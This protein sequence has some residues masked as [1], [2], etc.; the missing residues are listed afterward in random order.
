MSSALISSTM[1]SYSEKQALLR[2][3]SGSKSKLKKDLEEKDSDGEAGESAEIPYNGRV[4][5]ARKKAPLTRFMKG[6]EVN[7]NYNC[8]VK[9][10]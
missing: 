4:Y 5:L 2:R 6:F 9:L 1:V 8:D 10:D 7:R 3:G